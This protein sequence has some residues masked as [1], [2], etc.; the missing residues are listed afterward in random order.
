MGDIGLRLVVVVVAD[1]VLHGV[2]RKEL[3]ELRAELGRQGLVM[4]Q[5]QGGALHLLNDLGHGIGLAGTGDAQQDLL[6]QP[7]LHARRQLFDGLRLVP[8]GLVLGMYLEIRHGVSSVQWFSGRDPSNFA[9][10][11]RPMRA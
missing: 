11:A 9:F 8:G 2:L 4:G 6:I 5:H 7:C 3:L 1:E 10:S